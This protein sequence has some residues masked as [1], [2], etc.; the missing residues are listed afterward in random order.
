VELKAHGIGGEGAARQS[1][2]FIRIPPFFDVLLTRA[3]LIIEGDNTLGRP[4]Q[5]NEG[6]AQIQLARVPF[7]LGHD[8]GPFQLCA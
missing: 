1:G 4:R 3:S 6:D 8:R 7:D 2:P 5:V